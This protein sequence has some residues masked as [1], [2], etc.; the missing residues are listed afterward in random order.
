[1]IERALTDE[2]RPERSPADLERISRRP[3][4]ELATQHIRLTGSTYGGHEPA[5]STSR[6]HCELYKRR[7]PHGFIVYLEAPRLAPPLSSASAVTALIV[8]IGHHHC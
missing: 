1:M 3:Q 7:Q 6:M 4:I 2:V 8:A 5:R